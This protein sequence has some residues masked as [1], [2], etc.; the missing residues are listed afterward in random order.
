MGD[1][2][3]CRYQ[4]TLNWVGWGEEMWGEEGGVRLE[5]MGEKG[6]GGGGVCEGKTRPRN[7]TCSC[8]HL[9]PAILVRLGLVQ[10]GLE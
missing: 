7:R 6:G 8:T 4:P 3:G 9:N 2:W 1:G 10:L 5:K